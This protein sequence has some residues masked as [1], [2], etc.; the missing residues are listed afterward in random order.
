MI[1]AFDFG[2][3][4]KHYSA[5]ALTTSRVEG[6]REAFC[7]LTFGIELKS[8]SFL[9]VGFGQGLTALC[10]ADAGAAVCCLDV[11][12]RCAEALEL[13]SQFFLPKVKEKLNLIVGSILSSSDVRTLRE[14]SGDGYDVV[15]SWGVLHHTGDLQQA[16]ANCA[17][18]VK[19]GGHLIV[20]IYNRH[21]SSPLWERIKR[22]YC[23]LPRIG[24]KTMIGLFVPVIY[25]AKLLVTRRNPLEKERGMD[26][27]V[28]I[29]DWVGGYPYEYAVIDEVLDLGNKNSLQTLRVTPAGVPTGCN[30]FVF[31]K[32]A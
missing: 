30:E 11:N 13:T 21:W 5:R 31:T 17:G 29:V 28:D 20:A 8:R 12:P 23:R 2:S 16:F 7:E 24:Q 18:L 27:L 14:K 10:A 19:P 26:F 25:L 15:H 4:W 6:A 22:L 1:E 32:P 9:D 3:N